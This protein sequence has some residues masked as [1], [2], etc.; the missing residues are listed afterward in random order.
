MPHALP[1]KAKVAAP[2][3]KSPPN[4]H[5]ALVSQYTTQLLIPDVD[6][7]IDEVQY[8]NYNIPT[9]KHGQRVL[10]PRDRNV[11]IGSVYVFT[12]DDYVD[13]RVPPTFA[14]P[15]VPL[16]PTL[17]AEQHSRLDR[18]NKLLKDLVAGRS[19]SDKSLKRA[20]TDEQYAAYKESLTT[21]QHHSEIE[22]GDG[23][24]D[25]LRSYK[26]LLQQAD[27]EYNKYERMS[28]L[29]SSGRVRYSKDTI[30]RVYNK[31]DTLY[32]RALE[33]LEELWGSASPYEQHQIQQWMDR[34][35]DFDAGFDRTI[36]IGSVLIPRVRGS[37]SINALDSGLPKLSKRLKRKECQLVALRAAAFGLAFQE[38]VE[39]EEE[40]TD[41]QRTA[42]RA[43]SEKLRRLLRS[44]RDDDDDDY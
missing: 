7:C 38:P 4:Q 26:S 9:L 6:A 36:G 25:D 17:T 41:E 15:D 40:L 22:Y 42:I 44:M 31:S 19:V 1:A 21:Q 30:D 24:P 33:R 12:E 14:Q 8:T 39:P 18:L 27:F 32:E 35:I 34:D 13:A 29:S 37:K 23:V 43:Q 5:A 28:S 10:K 3:A 16:N 2:H 11:E 20:L